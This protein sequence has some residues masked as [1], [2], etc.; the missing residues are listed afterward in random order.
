MKIKLTSYFLLSMACSL[1]SQ[2]A[3]NVLF[4]N[5]DANNQLV[6]LDISPNQEGAY[7]ILGVV[8]N[9][10]VIGSSY[11]FARQ[12]AHH[13]DLRSLPEWSG[14]ID[15]LVST[16]PESAIV[17]KTLVNSSLIAEGDIFLASE[18]ISP[19][20]VNFI[21]PRIFGGWP[22]AYIL[23]LVIIISTLLLIFV[24]KKKVVIAAFIGILIA[25]M[26]MDARQLVDHFAIKRNIER[27]S[28]YIA[29][30]DFAEKFILKARPLITDTWT[31]E[32]K[33][34]DEYY[35]IYFQYAL[36]DLQYIWNLKNFELPSGTFIITQNPA[37]DQEIILQEDGFYLAKKR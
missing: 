9:N 34:T 27:N 32:G 18:K 19:K 22:F 28:Y 20:L 16:L 23:L 4:S 15:Y 37:Q 8:K 25:T 31:F 3:S 29:P 30:I 5:F 21:S 35:K 26:L 14:K 24:L 7:F 36:A 17:K 11:F 12:G 13:Y 2:Q 6:K 33:F 1:I 10:Q